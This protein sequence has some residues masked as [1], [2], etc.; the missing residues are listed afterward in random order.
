MNGV[1]FK[2]CFA[3]LKYSC[4]HVQVLAYSVASVTI[5][6]FS[7]GLI[8]AVKAEEVM[9]ALHRLTEESQQVSKMF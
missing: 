4:L 5:L 7:R 1:L 8:D 2:S 6:A 3:F 9:D